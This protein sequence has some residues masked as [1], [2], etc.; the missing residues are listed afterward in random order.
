MIIK[1]SIS[2][3]VCRKDILISRGY[4]E[5]PYFHWLPKQAIKCVVFYSAIGVP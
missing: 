4:L 5:S 3:M 1:Y 2:N